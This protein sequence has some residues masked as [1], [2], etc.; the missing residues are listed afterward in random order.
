MKPYIFPQVMKNDI[1]QSISLTQSCTVESLSG[2]SLAQIFDFQTCGTI[3][4]SDAGGAV[5]LFCLSGLEDVSASLVG[6]TV[7]GDNG[8]EGAIT[9]PCTVIEP[10]FKGADVCEGLFYVCVMADTSLANDQEC[11][12]SLECNGA[13]LTSCQNANPQ[14]CQVL[15]QE[16]SQ[17]EEGQAIANQ[18]GLSF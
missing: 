4:R 13:A 3:G 11:L 17:T 16:G 5:A 9:E 15:A 10:E 7:V 6:I 12:L 2:Q 18:F 14:D 8:V 1:S